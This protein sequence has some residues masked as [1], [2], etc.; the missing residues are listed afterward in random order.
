[1]LR[2][3]V[4]RPFEWRHVVTAAHTDVAGRFE[5]TNL[6]QGDYLLILT[7][8]GIIPARGRPVLSRHPGVIRVDHQQRDQT[9]PPIDLQF[10]PLPRA[11]QELPDASA[12]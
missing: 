8:P 2:F 12:T 3:R 10:V 11:P 9:L 7:G 4:V 1:M 5:L 6:P